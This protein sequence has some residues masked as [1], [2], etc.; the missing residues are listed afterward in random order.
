MT[1]HPQGQTG[2]KPLRH[3]PDMPGPGVPRPSTARFRDLVALARSFRRNARGAAAVE[4]ALVALPFISL[5]AAI[6]QNCLVVWTAQTLDESLQ[7]AVRTLYTGGFQTA[8]GSQTNATNLTKLKESICGTSAAR[9]VQ[10][11][12]CSNLKLDV[13]VSPNFAGAASLVPVALNS[14]TRTW[15]TN[16]GTR[17]SCAPPGSIAVVT[18]AIKY[19]VFFSFLNVGTP[20][21]SDGSRLIQST[22]VFRAEPNDTSS[23]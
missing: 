21:F 4:F 11:F 18:A 7:K 13:F 5:I 20:T 22:A 23:C 14:Q 19:P 16:F 10:V 1:I 17:Y 8:N 9:V 15:A 3:G 12:S 6:V 2:V